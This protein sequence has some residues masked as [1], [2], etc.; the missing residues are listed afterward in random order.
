MNV[1]WRWLDI[2]SLRS[3]DLYS[4]IVGSLFQRLK[5]AVVGI[6]PSSEASRDPLYVNDVVAATQ[7]HTPPP[8][9]Y[10]FA[11][12]LAK[13]FGCQSIID[14]GCGTSPDLTQIAA[15]FKL[16]HVDR[17]E[18]LPHFRQAHP[19]V[20]AVEHDL[21][22]RVFRMTDREL[23]RQSLIVCSGLIECSL[24]PPPLIATL[25]DLLA[26]APAAIVTVPEQH[27]VHGSGYA[28]A[29][30]NPSQARAW[31]PPEL[32]TWFQRAGMK[33]DLCGLTASNDRDWA[34]STTLALLRRQDA[35]QQ[36]KP[37]AAFRVLAFMCTY[38]EEDII[39]TVLKHVT[40]QGVEVH[41]VDNWST[42]RT[43]E[44]AQEFLGRGLTRITKYPVEGPS[45]T[46]DW[47]ALLT[48][49]E[50]LSA[51][52][53]ADWCIHYDA[54]EIRESPWPGVGL[55]DALF[56][57][58]GEGFNA[59]DHTCLVFHPTEGGAEDAADIDSYRHFEFGKRGGHF[60][61]IKA[62]KRQ[63]DR[64]R[65]AESGGH[66]VEFSGR[67]VYP[68]KFLLRHYPVRSQ[69][70]GIRKILGER[71][72]RWNPVERG[73]RGWHTHYDH[74]E[75]SHNFLMKATDLL[76]FDP[77]TFYRDYLVERLSGIGAE[78]G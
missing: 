29:A 75:A 51:A 76:E 58:D 37:P 35:E 18:N 39:Q 77:A 59:V 10:R 45:P 11:G 70:Q 1:S 56:R 67:K 8:D 54:D 32:E 55:R 46:Y 23:V 63:P 73:S 14:L 25:Q 69:E 65:L 24:D 36:F 22:A 34:K 15:D 12:F 40:S 3:P 9:V 19:E 13:R 68:Y 2:L 20:I 57:V 48:H 4:P 52:C 6:R 47:H 5:R 38:N 60:V 78:R 21:A 66:Q 62:W 41:L 33:V 49:V 53:D 61:Q 17:G 74:V 43:V 71:K 7:S 16:L 30:G 44:R 28:S 42:D 64:I 26:D 50:E 31:S 72:P 27:F